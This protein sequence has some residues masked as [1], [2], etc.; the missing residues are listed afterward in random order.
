[1]SKRRIH[2]T[3]LLNCGSCTSALRPSVQFNRKQ[4]GPGL[5][6][7]SIW[8]EKPVPNQFYHWTRGTLY[9]QTLVLT[10]PTSGGRSVGRVRSRTQATEFRFRPYTNTKQTGSSE[11]ASGLYSGGSQHETRCVC[12]LI[13]HFLRVFLSVQIKSGTVATSRNLQRSANTIIHC[14]HSMLKIIAH[15]SNPSMFY[16]RLVMCHQ[17]NQEEQ[18]IGITHVSPFKHSA[19]CMYYMLKHS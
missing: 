13:S 8:G 12:R 16:M 2:D 3:V 15:V 10:S 7:I 11:N 19:Y 4:E 9:S 6:P 5:M 17:T 18:T 14:Y 1:M